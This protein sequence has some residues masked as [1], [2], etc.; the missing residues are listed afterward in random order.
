MQPQRSPV[1]AG[2]ACGRDAS[3]RPAPPPSWPYEFHP[4]RTAG[5]RHERELACPPPHASRTKE[6]GAID[7]TRR[8]RALALVG[9]GI[10]ALL[11][12]GRGRPSEEL[13]GLQVQSDI[14]NFANNRRE[15]RQPSQ[16]AQV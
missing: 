6:L 16:F 8:R 10:G 13:V 11:R 14:A 2:T 9:F 7:L 1:N 5:R 3:S 12:E 4:T 15:Q